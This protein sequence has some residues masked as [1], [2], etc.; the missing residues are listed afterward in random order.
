LSKKEVRGGRRRRSP[1]VGAVVIFERKKKPV[2][3]MKIR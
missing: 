2:T 3:T 1:W